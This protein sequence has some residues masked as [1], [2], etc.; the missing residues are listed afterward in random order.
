MSVTNQVVC[1]QCGGINRVPWERLGDRPRCGACHRP[2]FEAKPITLGEAPT[3]AAR[4]GI[5]SIPTLVAF[6]NGREDDRLSDA[7]PAPQ[8]TS[9]LQRQQNKKTKRPHRGALG[10]A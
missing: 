3:L 2:L 8:L 6:R 7:L 10:A 4:Y 9:W 5:R 1:P